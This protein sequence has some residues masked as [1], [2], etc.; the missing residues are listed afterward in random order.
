MQTR[1]EEE[2]EEIP[3]LMEEEQEEEEEEEET[4][5]CLPRVPAARSRIGSFV[6]QFWTTKTW[7]CF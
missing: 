1:Q 6:S 3:P 7:I 4:V 5:H 2:Q